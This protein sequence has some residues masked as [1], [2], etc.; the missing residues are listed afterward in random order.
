MMA[1]K[2]GKKDP[3][4]RPETLQ[5][6]DHRDTSGITYPATFGYGYDY[7]DWLMLAN[8]PDPTV[9]NAPAGWSGCGDCVW[10]GSDHETMLIKK[11]AG[12]SVSFDGNTAV[13]DY[14][15]QTGYNISQTQPDG[16]NPTDNGT[17]VQQ[18]LQYRVNTGIIDLAG[19]RHKLGGFVA[20]EPGNITHL[21]EAMWIF[22]IVGIG[23]QFPDSAM[24]QFNNGQ[25]WSVVAGAQIEGGHYV[26]L[27]GIPSASE[28]TC[29]TWARRQVLTQAW[30]TKYCDE[31]YCYWTEDS[32]KNGV[33]A[34]GFSIAQQQAYLAIVA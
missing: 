1:Y 9:T 12:S 20:L 7:S 3:I 6:A 5:W 27:V 2:L 25:K 21:L 4:F 34:R 22:D 17:D 14:S 33:N 15:A 30:Y 28:L 19:N 23:V 29:V 11:Q 8:G 18:A 31:A 32:I 26:P 24:N 16:S 13:A 10:A